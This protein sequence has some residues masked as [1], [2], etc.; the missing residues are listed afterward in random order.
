MP[1]SQ[2]GVPIELPNPELFNHDSESAYFHYC[3]NETV[4]GIEWPK[5]PDYKGVLVADMS[6]N[7]V[8][9]PIDFSKLGMC[10]AHA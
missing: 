7:F 1:K 8:T 5:I 4:D 2:P 10:Y 9:R 3:D 6:S